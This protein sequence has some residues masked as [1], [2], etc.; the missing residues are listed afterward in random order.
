M[1]KVPHVIF[2]TATPMQMHWREYH[3]LLEL[4]GLPEAWTEPANYERSLR[5][6]LR[7]WH[8]HPAGRI[9]CRGAGLLVRQAMQPSSQGW[10]SRRRS[11][12][13]AGVISRV[14]SSRERTLAK[15]GLEDDPQT[16]DEATPRSSADCQEHADGSGGRRLHL[17]DAQSNGSGLDVSS[18]V[19][20]SFYAQVED[21]LDDRLLRAR[22]SSVPG[23]EVSTSGS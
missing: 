8:S 10:S 3:A 19:L 4:L 6:C 2:A 5:A 20:R 12:G 15:R 21:Y 14:T 11:S 22:T 23:P 18:D 13:T 17:P 16:P 7:R 1:P 9:S